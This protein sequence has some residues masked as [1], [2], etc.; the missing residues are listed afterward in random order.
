MPPGFSSLSNDSYET[1]S[2]TQALQ[3]LI[4]LCFYISAWA[5]EQ[6]LDN[7]I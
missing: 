4:V 1:G 6:E 5:G 7:A 2:S 3:L